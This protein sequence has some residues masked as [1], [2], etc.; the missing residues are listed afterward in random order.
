ME[1]SVF[2]DT[3]DGKNTVATSKEDTFMEVTLLWRSLLGALMCK[4]RD[5][6]AKLLC[7]YSVDEPFSV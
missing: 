4:R 2:L 3:D 7:T 6:S 1:D 5:R